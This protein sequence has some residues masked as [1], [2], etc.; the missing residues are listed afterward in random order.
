MSTFNPLGA[1]SSAPEAMRA[2]RSVFTPGFFAALAG[3]RNGPSEAI[4]YASIPVHLRAKRL[5]GLRSGDARV[6]PPRNLTGLVAA[7]G[8]AFR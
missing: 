4:N 8:M 7:V 1:T 3:A 5:G 6:P 2:K